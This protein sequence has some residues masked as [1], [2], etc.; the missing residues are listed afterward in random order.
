MAAAQ[1]VRITRTPADDY[2]GVAPL[3]QQIVLTPHGGEYLTTKTNHYE[4]VYMPLQARIYLFDDKMQPLTARDVHAQMSLNLPR[5]NVP[6][7]IPFQYVAMPAGVT[8]QDYVVAAFD[9]R[10]LPDKETPITLEFSGLPDSHKFLGLWDRHAGTASFTPSFSPSKIRPYVARV[11][12]TEADREGFRRQML[13]PVSGKMLGTERPAI[14]LYIAD[15]PLYL[16]GEDCIAAVKQSPEKYLPN[17][18]R[19]FLAGERRRRPTNRSTDL[20]HG[21]API[22]PTIPSSSSATCTWEMEGQGQLPLG[23]REKQLNLFLDY[24]GSQQGELIIL[25]D[26]FD[27]WQMNL[28]KIVMMHMPLLDRLAAMNATYVL[29]NHDADFD[30]FVGT[31]FLSHPLFKKMCSPIR[32]GD[33]RQAVQV[34]AR[35]RS[36]SGQLGRHAGNGKNLLHRC[37]D[38]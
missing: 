1:E 36:R 20:V 26:L 17:P 9:F 19:R 13:C 2:R 11:L 4:I 21:G 14:K 30:H 33:R 7:K 12:L 27:F 8:E 3:P 10:Q 35:A 22:C 24:V 15:Y 37:R 29:G 34:H 6:Q 16:S 5:Q 25:G 32:A 18:L 23:D 28:S 38:E 31:G